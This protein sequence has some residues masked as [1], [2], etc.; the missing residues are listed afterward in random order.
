MYNGGLKT[1]NP[2]D[3]VGKYGRNQA[4]HKHTIFGQMLQMFSRHEF[5]KAVKE[6]QTEYHA[7]GFKS[8][9]HFVAMF[10]GQVAGQ[11][12]LRG[13]EAGLATQAQNI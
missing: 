3:I 11:D 8:W 13:I 4:I 10:F 2:S 6:S 9:N 5:E 12:S 1:T 7:R